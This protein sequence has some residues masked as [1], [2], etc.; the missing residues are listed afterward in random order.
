MKQ[1]NKDELTDWINYKVESTMDNLSAG[2]FVRKLNDAIKKNDTSVIKEIMSP[3]FCPKFKKN[4]KEQMIFNNVVRSS[5]S[6]FVGNDFLNYLIFDYKISE[7]NS[8]EQIQ[9]SDKIKA[10]FQARKLDEELRTELV[11]TKS[12]FKKPKV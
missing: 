8:I 5:I 9:V 11:D 1:I 3:E 2:Q 12:Q 10:M 4:V 6:K 7:A